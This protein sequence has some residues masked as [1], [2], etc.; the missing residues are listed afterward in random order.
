MVGIAFDKRKE[1]EQLSDAL[2]IRGIPS[3]VV[4]GADGMIITTDGRSKIMADPK[5]DSFPSGWLPQPC[6]DVNDD[7]RRLNN[8]QC[9]ILF[10]GPGSVGAT[11]LKAVAAECYESV[12]K[13]VESMPLQFFRASEGDVTQQ[14][15][16]LT[17]FEGK[18]LVLLDIPDDGGFYVCEESEITVDIVREFIRHVQEK[19]IVRKQLERSM[20]AKRKRVD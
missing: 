17:K 14:L 16:E 4:I 6:N 19:R 7:P 11:A 1:K 15:R 5:G 20:H 2:G 10:D 9:V 3:F 18:G 8:E 13:V 12:G